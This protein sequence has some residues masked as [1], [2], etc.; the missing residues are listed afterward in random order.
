MTTLLICGLM[1]TLVAF[2]GEHILLG[3]GSLILRGPDIPFGCFDL[4]TLAITGINTPFYPLATPEEF[5]VTLACGG[6]PFMV[7]NSDARHPKQI[8]N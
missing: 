1:L 3:F 8:F 7:M 5:C 2:G 6:R 4:Y